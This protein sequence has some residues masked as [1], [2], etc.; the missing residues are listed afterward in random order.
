MILTPKEELQKAIAE[1]RACFVLGIGTSIATLG[2]PDPNNYVNWKG[3][4][5]SGIKT[6]VAQNLNPSDE[7]ESICRMLLESSE[8]ENKLIVGNKIEKEL[9]GAD[10]GRYQKWLEQTVGS[11]HNLE[12]KEDNKRLLQR[13]HSMGLPI[14]TTNYDNLIETVTGRKCLTWKED[15]HIHNSLH[16]A[17][18]CLHLHGHWADSS[19]VIL[20]SKSYDKLIDG[21]NK[22]NQALLKTLGTV[23]SLIFVG[24]NEGLKDPNFTKLRAWMSTVLKNTGQTHYILLLDSLVAQFKADFDLNKELITPIGYGN[25]HGD[26]LP[27]LEE[28][29]PG[30]ISIPA[31]LPAPEPFLPP[32]FEYLRVPTPST[33]PPKRYRD[34]LQ[35][36]HLHYITRK[37]FLIT[38]P[39][40]QCEG[41]MAEEDYINKLLG[42]GSTYTSCIIHGKGG[43]GKSRL[44]LELGFMALQRGWTVIRVKNT[45]QDL[46]QLV[47]TFSVGGKYVL[48]FD[49]I[50]DNRLFNQADI[51]RLADEAG[52]R[53]VALANCRNTFLNHK[54]INV[55]DENC[56]AINLDAAPDYTQF[57]IQRLLQ[58]ATD[59][60]IINPTDYAQV[61]PAF[62][63]FLVF[64]KA[65]NPLH[66]VEIRNLSHF[67]D[68]VKNRLC[69]T[70]GV[71]NWDDISE[72]AFIL[73]AQLP[74]KNASCQKMKADFETR[75]ILSK[76][77]KD[78]W[79]EES[80]DGSETIL[81]SLHDIISDEI[82]IGHYSE[83]PT[84]IKEKLNRCF[85]KSISLSTTSSWILSHERIFD[86][87]RFED[88]VFA[89][90]LGSVLSSN[91]KALESVHKEICFTEVI[92]TNERFEIFRQYPKPFESTFTQK[93]FG[94]ILGYAGGIA[95]KLESSAILITTIKHLL[96]KWISANPKFL[97]TEMGAKITAACINLASENVEYKKQAVEYVEK[98]AHESISRI[99]LRE[100]LDAKIFPSQVKDAVSIHLR[101]HNAKN[102]SS[103]VLCSWLSNVDDPYYVK[104]HV[105]VFLTHNLNSYDSSSFVITSWLENTK[106]LEAIKPHILKLINA[107]LENPKLNFVLEKWIEIGKDL[108]LIENQIKIFLDLN[109]DAFDISFIIKPWL[110]SK[111]NPEIVQ[112]F[113]F[114]FL[115]RQ[116]N[117][118]STN[119]VIRAWLKAT[120]EVERIEEHLIRY[121]KSN[122]QS[123][124]AQYV[125]NAWLEAGGDPHLIRPH[126]N[127]YLKCFGEIEEASF[128]WEPWIS[129]TREVLPFKEQ[130]E[131]YLKLHSTN[132][133]STYILVAAVTAVKADIWLRPYVSKNLSAV[134][135]PTTKVFYKLIITWINAG[136]DYEFIKDLLPKHEGNQ[137]LKYFFEEAQ[138]LLRRQTTKRGTPSPR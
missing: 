58:L 23:G 107:N 38:Y 21:E 109:K 122:D 79:V 84:D 129:K 53:I 103:F 70:L 19:S 100:L 9:G 132:I 43:L 17:D 13:I 36:Y 59:G 97:H 44:T 35:S 60:G 72:D 105:N 75:K 92:T 83:N 119:F 110:S 112:E 126:V 1:R 77:I 28:L 29:H 86:V 52:L 67:R 82:L 39:Y 42:H 124:E 4:L 88:G 98:Y 16:K 26:L 51:E 99:T 113:V 76:L 2:G 71:Q 37:E 104:D 57:V 131:M 48:L 136:G 87:C 66:K 27:F 54:R 64:L 111:G 46:Q 25:S 127:N 94:Q 117:P 90:L 15:Y 130:L 120:K 102:F 68:W 91:Y 123:K 121:L 93:W 30:A 101:K 80:N 85:L 81:E 49:Y 133:N 116:N 33:A 74:A 34:Y 65:R 20:G 11:L 61:S 118:S 55:H 3:L 89:E 31:S 41:L 96:R 32:G 8:L 115:G 47:S 95:R 6:V 56:L 22:Y 138:K 78:G 10:H 50:E 40:Q 134:A 73:F 18:H 108:A 69:V 7:W 128:V 45:A 125:I 12:I 135:K 24:V 114:E 137:K 5:E 106:D 62:A 63:V 14:T